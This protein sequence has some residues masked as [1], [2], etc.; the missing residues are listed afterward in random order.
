MA[1][2]RFIGIYKG[3]GSQMRSATAPFESLYHEFVTS[4]DT[5]GTGEESA[6][7]GR[8]KWFTEKPLR[9]RIG[10]PYMIEAV[11]SPKHTLQQVKIIG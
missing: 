7:N 8:V 3:E 2:Q 5:L 4:I 10:Q 1:K 11:I 9:L 6:R